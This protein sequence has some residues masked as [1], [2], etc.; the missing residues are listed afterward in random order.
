M[1]EIEIYLA[2]AEEMMEKAIDHTKSEFAKI[3]A[4]KAMPSMVDGIS[5]EYYGNMSNDLE[6][7]SNQMSSATAYKSKGMKLQSNM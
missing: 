2:T 7:M 5:V 1:E 3:R 6:M 4:G